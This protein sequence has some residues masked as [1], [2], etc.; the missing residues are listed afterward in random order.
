MDIPFDGLLTLLI[1]LVGIPAIILQMI[2]SAERRAVMKKQVLDVRNSLIWALVIIVFG[3]LLHFFLL[4][5]TTGDWKQWG[6]QL[7]WVILFAILFAQVLRV[8]KKIPEQYGRREKIIEKLVEQTQREADS[9]TL[10]RVGGEAFADL[11]NLGKQCDAGPE[12]EMV[13]DAFKVLVQHIISDKRY[14]GDSFEELIEELVHM[15]VSNPEQKD[16]CCYDTAIKVMSAILS[17][18]GTITSD[19]DKRRVLHAISKLGRTLLEHFESVEAD[20]I[21][22]DYVDSVEFAILDS[23][24]MLTDVSQTL[25]EIGACASSAKQDFIAVATLDKMTVLAESKSPWPKEFTADILGLI[26]HFWTMGGS[27]QEFAMQKL[28]EIERLLPEDALSAMGDASA[29]CRRTLYFDTADNLKKM[30]QEWHVQLKKE[31]T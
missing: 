21:I 5:L 15:L 9:K 25:F 28:E 3:F 7:I 27:R 12:R 11:A 13:V 4:F 31:T 29:H 2:S 23:A 22:L 18:N 16:L 10:P 14:D 19:S 17:V 26:S 1:F 6:W 30:S 24:E 8:S 20:N